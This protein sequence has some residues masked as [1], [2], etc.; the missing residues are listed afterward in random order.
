[1]ELSKLGSV[2]PALFQMLML[3][4]MHLQFACSVHASTVIKVWLFQHQRLH[5]KSKALESQIDGSDS[6][7]VA[8]DV[9]PL[10]TT[11]L[12]RAATSWSQGQPPGELTSLLALLSLEGKS[13]LSFAIRAQAGQNLRQVPRAKA[14]V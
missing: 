2:F 9:L 11:G 4:S 3:G 13:A 10:A 8:M 5:A 7:C 12:S 1:M 14:M 6:V